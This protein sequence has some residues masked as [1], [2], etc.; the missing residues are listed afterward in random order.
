VISGFSDLKGR[1]EGIEFF[2]LGDKKGTSCYNMS[3]QGVA[4]DCVRRT[5]D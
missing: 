1:N 4:R 2:S 3:I 5:G